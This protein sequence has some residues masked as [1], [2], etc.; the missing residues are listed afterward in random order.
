MIA[1][2][3]KH[4]RKKAWPLESRVVEKPT[5]ASQAEKEGFDGEKALDRKSEGIFF[6]N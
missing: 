4:V 1:E 5:K 6:N 3:Q 2:L